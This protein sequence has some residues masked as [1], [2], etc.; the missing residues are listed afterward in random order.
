MFLLFQNYTKYLFIP[1]LGFLVV[2]LLVPAIMAFANKIGMV[3]KPDERRIHKGIIPRG[4][5]LAVFIGFHLACAA[6]YFL[7]WYSFD[8]TLSRHWWFKFLPASIFLVLVGVADDRWGLQPRIKLGC[9]VVAALAVYA[10]GIHI[11]SLL[12]FPL[13]WPVD[14]FLTILWCVGFMNAFN[15]IDGLDGLATG[16]GIIAAAGVAGSMVIQ[17]MPGNTL[18]LLGLV[19]SCLGFLRFNFNPARVFLGDTGSMFIGFTLAA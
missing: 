13:P 6:I 18:V 11:G 19:G 8:I 2:Y 15:L 5:G 4:G 3:D 16:L 9:Q 17:H 1:L 14:C 12:Y 7:P 10:W